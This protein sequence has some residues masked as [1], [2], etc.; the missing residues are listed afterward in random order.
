MSALT[1]KLKSSIREHLARRGR[2]QSFL[3]LALILPIL[4]I[5][6][7]G[8][9]EIV[10]FIGRYLDVLDLT[11][12]AA[13]FAS[14]RDPQ[15]PE[16][17]VG[18]S[19]GDMD[20]STAGAFNFFYDTACIFSPPIGSAACWDPDYCNG[21]NPYMIMNPATDD[22]IVTVF[23]ISGISGLPAVEQTWPNDIPVAAGG[24]GKYW[25]LSNH[26][27]DL[28]HND[29]W[30]LNCQGEVTRSE[31]HYT[32]SRITPELIAAAPDSKGYVAVEFFYC[33]NQILNLPLF[34]EFVPNPIQIHA[35]TIMPLP[36][37]RP[38]PTPSPSP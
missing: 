4:L 11:R 6:L 21:L 25:A 10:V 32:E 2:G 26:D 29:N 28:V 27:S 8:M 24:D 16:L 23:T 9:V 3:E 13:R 35:Y 17:V 19:P 5:M 7:V 30:M 38:T 36:S 34:T 18:A 31:P 37:A 12:E 15:I 22:V 20:C 33:Y 1:A 14:Q